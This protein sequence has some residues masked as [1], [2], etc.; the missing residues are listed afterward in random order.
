MVLN[1][2]FLV[3][4]CSIRPLFEY[5]LTFRFFVVSVRNCVVI[6]W[7]ILPNSIYLSTV[8]AVAN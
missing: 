7:C 4:S 1:V 2:D 5:Y 3:I 6:Y 8:R